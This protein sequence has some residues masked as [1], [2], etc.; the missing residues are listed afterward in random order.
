VVVG[1]GDGAAKIISRN[2]LLGVVFGAD[3]SALRITYFGWAELGWKLN[4]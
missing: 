2:P 1:V 4:H 3:L